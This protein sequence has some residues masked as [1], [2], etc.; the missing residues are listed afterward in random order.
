MKIDDDGILGADG[1]YEV[2]AAPKGTLCR[3]HPLENI[4]RRVA[5]HR[6]G[7]AGV[8]RPKLAGAGM[9]PGDTHLIR[10]GC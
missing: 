6:A 9:G 8:M 7:F 4:R 10:S 1:G 5:G 2:Q 3:K